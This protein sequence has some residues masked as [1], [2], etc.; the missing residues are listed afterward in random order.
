MKKI[1]AERLIHKGINRVALRFPY[2][3]ELIKIAKGLADPLWSSQMKCWHIPDNTDIITL[4]LKAFY[5]K[6]YI[7]YTSLKP[8]LIEKIKAK[9]EEEQRKITVKTRG[10]DN[11]ELHPLS[12]K[13]RGDI[14]KYRR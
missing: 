8:N 2:D 9:K 14:E 12:E 5:G 4:L 6:A 3:A 10:M 11:P 13:G 1:V 7:D